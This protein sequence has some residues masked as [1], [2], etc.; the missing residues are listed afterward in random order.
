MFS[1]FFFLQTTHT[2]LNWEQISSRALQALSRTPT[3]ES[4][5]IT[6]VNVFLNVRRVQISQA[7][8]QC[9]D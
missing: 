2:A 1:F 6:D 4:H 9:C 7:A 8:P 3:G 5:N